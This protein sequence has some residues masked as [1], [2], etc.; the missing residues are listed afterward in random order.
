MYHSCEKDQC[1]SCLWK[2][3]HS[4]LSNKTQPECEAQGSDHQ[5]CGGNASRLA[6]NRAG[7]A[8]NNGI[9]NKSKNTK[10]SKNASKRARINTV[11][12]AYQLPQATGSVCGTCNGCLLTS[13]GPEQGCYSTWSKATC[14]AQGSDYQWCGGANPPVNSVNC[15]DTNAAH[16]QIVVG[17]TCPSGTTPIDSCNSCTGSVKCANP[18]Y[19]G[20]GSGAGGCGLSTILPNNASGLARWLKI[21]P[22]L[23]PSSTQYNAQTCDKLGLAR[24]NMYSAGCLMFGQGG[25]NGLSAFLQVAAQFT[26]FADGPDSRKNI[27]ELASFFGN[28]SQETGD[29]VNG[30]LLYSAELVA[31]PCPS[32]MFGKGPIQLTG[33][34]NYQMATLGLNKP[35]DFNDLITKQGTLTGPCALNNLYAPTDDC[36]TQCAAATPTPPPQGAGYNYCAKPWLASGLNDLGAVPKLDPVPSWASALWYWM[37]VPVNT[38]LAQ[39]FYNIQGDVTCATAHNLVQDPA[40]NCGDWCPITAIAQV[41]CESCC[42][43]QAKS[44]ESMTVN[45]IGN[46]VKI[47]AILGLPEAQ[48]T[49]ANDL[50]CMLLNTCYAGAPN[51]KGATCPANYSYACYLNGT[52]GGGGGGGTTPLCGNVKHAAP[53]PSCQMVPGNPAGATQTSCDAC[54][55]GQQWW[56]CNTPGACQWASN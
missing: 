56:P 33:A 28:V 2:P 16:C 7:S 38:A 50:F 44:I 53:T 42:T 15:C 34:I 14:D 21:F 41:G 4:C 23:D 20:G 43:N 31:T 13:V 25:Q 27:I 5:W 46:F 47:A 8:S 30:G 54:T 9:T 12:A 3:Y 40:Y 39:T 45:R 32:S 35:S 10:S 11:R 55:T 29:A 1:D 36:W 18:Y 51:S 49:A 48:G 52:C 6:Y 37:N 24:P 22:V 17:S 26:G 19:T